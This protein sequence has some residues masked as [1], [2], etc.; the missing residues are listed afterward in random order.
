LRDFAGHATTAGTGIWF[1]RAGPYGFS[2]RINGA[3]CYTG[4]FII[5]TRDGLTTGNPDALD[6]PDES[7]AAALTD[8]ANDRLAER[9][10]LAPAT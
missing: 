6:L 7:L 1:G 3:L 10:D 8:L 9:D 2:T 5:T 4:A